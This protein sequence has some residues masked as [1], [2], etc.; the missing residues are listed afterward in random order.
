MI[1]SGMFIAGAIRQSMEAGESAG[2]AAVRTARDARGRADIQQG[3]IE[4]L[5]MITEALWEFLKEERGYT[6]AELIRKIEAIDMRDGKLD[7]KVA[8]QPNLACPS[9]RRTMIG[10]HTVCLYCGTAVERSPFER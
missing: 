8:K 10:K 7:G 4:R 5:F 9:C 6:D 1:P 2:R 3:D